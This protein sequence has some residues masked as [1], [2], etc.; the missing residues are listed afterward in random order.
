MAEQVGFTLRFPEGWSEVPAA[1]DAAASARRRFVFAPR[2]AATGAQLVRAIASIEVRPRRGITVEQ[3]LARALSERP[4]A[5]SPTPPPSA[6]TSGA[7]P[8]GYRLWRREADTV[9]LAGLPCVVVHDVFRP[10]AGGHPAL[11]QRLLVTYFPPGG[12]VAVQ[13]TL[14]SPDL[15]A[16]DD[17]LADGLAIAATLTLSAPPID[18]KRTP[19]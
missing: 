19:A 15:L 18:L 2:E 5:S 13:F 16:F 14:S 3:L 4:D 10:A 12:E 6:A 17:F 11:Q 8:G 7:V 9:E 1:P